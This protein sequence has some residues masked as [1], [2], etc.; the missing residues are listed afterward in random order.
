MKAKESHLENDCDSKS[1]GNAIV[2]PFFGNIGCDWRGNKHSKKTHDCKLK[3]VRKARQVLAS[4]AA[5]V[6]ARIKDLSN[7][8]SELEGE[9]KL[10][11]A[12]QYC[13]V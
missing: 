9:S 12:S 1:C 4:F 5:T 2:D 3:S 13:S 10:L 6:A 8:V 7:R 11:D